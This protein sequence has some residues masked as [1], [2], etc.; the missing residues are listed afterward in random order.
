MLR[1]DLHYLPPL[2]SFARNRVALAGDAAQLRNP[3]AI[4]VRNAALR[5]TPPAAFARSVRSV[6]S[7]TAPQASA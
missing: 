6:V 1:H 4:A 2:D 7:W 5:L 3:A